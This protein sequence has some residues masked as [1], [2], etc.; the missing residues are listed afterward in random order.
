MENRKILTSLLLVLTIGLI[1]GVVS[2]NEATCYNSDGGL[3][4]FTKGFLNYTNY[5]GE[6]FFSY[7]VC[8]NET[9]LV[10]G[11][12]GPNSI[13]YDCPTGCRD[14]AC[15]NVPFEDETCYNSDGG[16]NY[17]TKGYAV[18]C[19]DPFAEVCEPIKIS[20]TC[21]QWDEEGASIW[22]D[23]GERVQE[24]TCVLG[25]PDVTEYLC[26]N[27]CLN[28]ACIDISSG[29]F[30]CTDTD[31]GR[32]C[33]K[34]VNPITDEPIPIEIP[35]SFKK[36]TILQSLCLGC[37]KEDTCYPL[38]Y[39]REGNFCSENKNF[40]QQLKADSIC[41]NNFECTSN[42]CVSGKC[43]S[44]SFIQRILNWFT[45]LFGRE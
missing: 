13:M 10:E 29:D 5:E 31:K 14:G 41:D 33:L 18:G 4:Y 26:P 17:F 34:S 37:L 15:I 23:Y 19:N 35:D 11:F 9:T 40:V 6:T 32:I 25:G 43:I 7:D 16:L 12:C 22:A 24:V 27:G 1:F 44:D 38:G 3:N 20:D 8:V 28:G 39:R 2:A 21:L 45:R 36:E 30:V 42:V